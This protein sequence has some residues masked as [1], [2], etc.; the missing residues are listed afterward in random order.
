MNRSMEES[1]NIG[2]DI[3]HLIPGYIEQTRRQARALTT[4]LTEERFG[5]IRSIAHNLQGSGGSFGFPVLTELGMQLTR[6]ADAQD[7]AAA[8]AVVVELNIFARSASVALH[9]SLNC[10]DARN[11][12]WLAGKILIID[13]APEMLKM[14]A[15]MLR[16]DGHQVHIA[17]NAE[18]GL[19]LL[20]TLRT[21]AILVELRLPGISGLEFTRSVRKDPVRKNAVI[22][23]M[24]AF[25]GDEIV[26]AA[27]EA[28][29]DGFI[30]KPFDTE[31]LTGF[32]RRNLQPQF[33]APPIA[34]AGAAAEPGNQKPAFLE[35]ACGRCRALVHGFDSGFE[36]SCVRRM[37]RQWAIQAG[38]LRY[39]SISLLAQEA[40]VL[41]EGLWW[42]SAFLEEKPE[43]VAGCTGSPM[44]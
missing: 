5:E 29:F 4:M 2:N 44:G 33:E 11:E 3:E 14:T 41:L 19:V 8:E 25:S 26:K 10:S 18:Q 16:K 24:T 37:L 32:L 31:R 43:R 6:A 38:Q 42:D 34:R 36:T 1:A 30:T 22:L 23:A 12:T 39:G 15:A 17:S 13:G 28:G 35:D 27:A 9:A 20:Q 7:H 40:A 21:D